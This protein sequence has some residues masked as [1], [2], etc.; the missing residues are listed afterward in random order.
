MEEAQKENDIIIGS[1]LP[2][3]VE[4]VTT[5]HRARACVYFIRIHNT[6]FFC[7][8]DIVWRPINSQYRLAIGTEIV[9]EVSG[10][11]TNIHNID[12]LF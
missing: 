6:H 9:G 5:K 2:D 3:I 7:D 11:A 4:R 12:F 10:V 1:R 8:S